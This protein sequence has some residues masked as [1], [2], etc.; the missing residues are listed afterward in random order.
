MRVFFLLAGFWCPQGSEP[1]AS[2]CSKRR[3]A[4]PQRLSPLA[5]DGIT[6]S[7]DV[8]AV[9]TCFMNVSPPCEKRSQGVLGSGWKN[10]LLRLGRGDCWLWECLGPECAPS[11]SR[12]LPSQV[13]SGCRDRG[14][15]RLHM[16]SSESGNPG[17]QP[18]HR[19][20]LHQAVQEREAGGGPGPALWV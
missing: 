2:L 10:Y 20:S 3:P 16:R 17:I 12:V 18:D 14:V 4:A 15:Q 11:L 1:R 19:C 6:F 7:L 5:R 13:S 9:P 8:E